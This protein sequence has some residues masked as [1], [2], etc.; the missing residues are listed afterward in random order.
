[1]FLFRYFPGVW[2]LIADVSELPIAI[3]Y[4]LPP[5]T[6]CLSAPTSQGP[7]SYWL[8][9][10]TSPSIPT[11]PTGIYTLYIM[12]MAFFI[13][14]PMKMEPIRSSETSAI[15]TQTPGNYPKRNILQLK[16]GESLKTRLIMIVYSEYAFSLS[17]WGCMHMCCVV[18]WLWPVSL[19]HSFPALPCTRY[20]FREK[21]S[22][23]EIC[24]LTF[25]TNF[26]W[27]ISH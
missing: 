19:Y 26:V 21:F 12:S 9:L 23:R 11:Y 3:I 27:N 13:H 2:V 8:P 24:V 20:Y 6:V 14:L 16:Q 15:K 4:T 18:F 1:M 25:F 10:P 7:S 5:L 17:Y 22:E